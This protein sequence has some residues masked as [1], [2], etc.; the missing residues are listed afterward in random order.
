MKKAL[1]LALTLLFLL[2]ACGETTLPDTSEQNPVNTTQGSS[3]PDISENC[4][5]YYGL[6]DAVVLAEDKSLPLAQNAGNGYET[7][8]SVWYEGVYQD[9]ALQDGDNG[10]SVAD[11]TDGKASLDYGAGLVV[12]NGERYHCA[13]LTAQDSYIPNISPNTP[14]GILLL[15]ISGDCWADGGA[16]DLGCFS[17][18]S[19]V[20]I[21]G[22]GTLR[23]DGAGIEVSTAAGSLSSLPALILDGPSLTLDGLYLADRVC[24]DGTPS[25]FVRSGSLD[26]GTLMLTGDLCIAGGSAKVQYING[27]ENAVFRGGT[28]ETDQW[29]DS[30]V[31]TLIL[32]GGDATCTDWLPQGTSIEIGAGTMTANGIRHWDTVHVYDS[33]KIVDPMD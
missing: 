33:G 9:L 19:T 5:L 3:Q 18:F 26:A 24:D 13:H 12:W 6:G 7:S 14:G 27:V 31:P 11:M 16:E 15:E 30:V 21:C 25:L 17:G 22:S 8:Y 4:L 2:T 28:F 20:V 32:S 23:I 10:I 29:D 1:C